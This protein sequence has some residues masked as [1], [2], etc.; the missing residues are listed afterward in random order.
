VTLSHLLN[1]KSR[2]TPIYSPADP[3]SAGENEAG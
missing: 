2:G 1:R 3:K